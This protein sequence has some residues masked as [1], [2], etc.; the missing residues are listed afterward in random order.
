MSPWRPFQFKE[1]LI[2][3]LPSSRTKIVQ[4]LVFFYRPIG[5]QAPSVVVSKTS[6]QRI[7]A[8]RYETVV[9][10]GACEC[11]IN[12][13]FSLIVRHTKGCIKLQRVFEE[14]RRDKKA[15]GNNSISAA[16]HTHGVPMR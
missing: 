3:T 10:I 7:G 5:A 1:I 6:I 16:H 9:S 2:C 4:P 13:Q 11:R 12:P 14:H 8:S 15:T